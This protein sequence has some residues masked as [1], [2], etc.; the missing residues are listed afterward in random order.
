M[1]PRAILLI[2]AVIGVAPAALRSL[3]S[4][5]TSAVSIAYRPVSLSFRLY[6]SAGST[7]AFE[8][9]EL[10]LFTSLCILAGSAL[11]IS[12]IASIPRAN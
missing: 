3:I 12:G 2:L 6:S 5:V 4:L 1:T 8:Y 7:G 11:L 10:P 9:H